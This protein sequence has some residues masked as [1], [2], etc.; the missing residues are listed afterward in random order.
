MSSNT[1]SSAGIANS[2]RMPASATPVSVASS[3]HTYTLP[4]S[5]VKGRKPNHDNYKPLALKTCGSRPACLVNASVTYCGNNSIYAFGGFDQY[6]DEGLDLDWPKRCLVMTFFSL[7]PCS[8][9]RPREHAM[10]LGGQL[11]RH[12]RRSNGYVNTKIHSQHH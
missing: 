12:T 1:W 6:T 7:Q 10:E 3:S 8:Q 11:W 9:T 2:A 4:A 5:P